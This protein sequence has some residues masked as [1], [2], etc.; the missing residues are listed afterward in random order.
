MKYFHRKLME[1]RISPFLTH[2]TGR[3]VTGI[4]MIGMIALLIISGCKKDF[5]FDKVKDLAW[6]PDF[7]LALVNDTITL[8]KVL[9]QNGAGDNLYIDDSGN[10]SILYYYNH[11]AFKLLPN[12]L[13]RISPFSFP[14]MHQITHDEQNTLAISDLTLQAVT[15]TLDLPL[16][17]QEITIDRIRVKT[18]KIRVTTTNTFNNDGTLTC[19]ILNATK[20]GQPFSFTITPFVSG[21]M[22][23][24]IDIAD[25]WFELAATQNKL[26]VEVEGLVKK[27]GSPI[28]GD[29]I[30]ADFEISISSIGR[31]E[32]YLGQ[33]VFPQLMDS[34]RIRVFNNAY[35]LGQIHFMDPQDSITIVNSIGI[36]T[37]ITIE[38]MVAINNS[39]AASLDIASYLGSGAIIQVPSPLINATQPTVSKMVY[40]NANT[41][42]A[43]DAFFNMKPDWV[44]FQVKTRTNPAGKTTNFF[45]DTDSCFADLRVKLPLWGHFDHLTF[46][47]TF[48]LV[49]DKPEELEHLEFRTKISNG[50]PLTARMQVYFTDDKYNKKDSLAGLDE[51]FITEAPIDPAT[52]LPYP[53]VF[54]EKDTSI[55]LDMSR[56]QNLTNVKK[57]LVR[58]VLNSDNN[59]QVNVKMKAEQRL[60]LNFSA[61][62]KLRKTIKISK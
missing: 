30:R 2:Q 5:Q 9:T 52:D 16:N 36:P 26:Q 44:A 37:E 28:A 27:S 18:G 4:A 34:V 33:Q 31:F 8:R 21:Q 49:I 1:K 19:R 43:M 41:G 62:A 46:Q 61:R 20:N 25:V 24:D 51:I 32:G 57:M 15:L 40:T 58:A 53:G 60:K 47:D 59:G 39:S 45:S 17:N 6:N 10:I 7:A 14:Y 22:Q 35:V 38:K 48:D 55:T 23:K 42:N 50:L 29:Q 56:M 54:G 13:I 3:I 12:D 11:D